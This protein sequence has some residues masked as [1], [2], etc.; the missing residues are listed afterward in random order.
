MN[1]AENQNDSKEIKEFYQN[2]NAEDV[3][4]CE[5]FFN[6]LSP[7]RVQC[8][9]CNLGFFDNPFDPFPIDEI[10]KSTV[11]ERARQ[12]YFKRKNKKDVEKHD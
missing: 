9:K 11:N 2:S 3:N 10:N 5:H 6:R 12:N 4:S 7:T 1:K 8:K